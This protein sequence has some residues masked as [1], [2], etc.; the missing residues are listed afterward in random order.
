[1]SR[2]RT[3]GSRAMHAAAANQAVNLF[4]QIE[5]SSCSPALLGWHAAILHRIAVAASGVPR[6]SRYVHPDASSTGPGL[7]RPAPAGVAWPIA[8]PMVHEIIPDYAQR[9]AG[10]P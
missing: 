7:P 2:S 1:M 9:S 6:G 5:P 4:A 8:T 3:S 10:I